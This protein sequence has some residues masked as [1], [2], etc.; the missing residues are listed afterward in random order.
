M[1]KQRGVSLMGLLII[2]SM[3]AFLM[4]LGFK[5]VPAYVEYFSLK[6]TLQSL[7]VEQKSAGPEEIRKAFERR[8]TI[9]D[10]TSVKGD[11]LDITK[12]KDSLVIAVSYDKIVPMFSNVSVL[13]KFD[14]ASDGGAAA[15]E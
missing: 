11:D 8:A 5:L 6:K 15:A 3:V 2:G 12:E 14:V 10:I 9:D 7:A 4:L 1:H 13:I